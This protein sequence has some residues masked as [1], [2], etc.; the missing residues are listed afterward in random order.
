MGTASEDKQ[1]PEFKGVVLKKTGSK[2]GSRTGSP[3][4][5][6]C[7]SRGEMSASAASLLKKVEMSSSLSS[8]RRGSATSETAAEFANVSLKKT[9]RVQGDQSKFEVEQVSLRPIPVGE[10]EETTV[11]SSSMGMRREERASSVTR[12]RVL[13]ET[14]FEANDEEYHDIKSSLDRLKKKDASPAQALSVEDDAAEGKKKAS[15]KPALAEDDAAAK[16][17]AFRRP[18]RLTRE[19]EEAEKVQLKPIDRQKLSKDKTSAIDDN[20]DDEVAQSLALRRS[21]RMAQEKEQVEKVQLKQVNQEKSSKD[22]SITKDKAAILSLAEEKQEKLTQQQDAEMIQPE[23]VKTKKSSKDAS[24]AK[25]DAA[26]KPVAYRRPKKLP[27]EEEDEAEKVHLKPISREKKTFTSSIECLKKMT[28]EEERQEMKMKMERPV[29]LRKMSYTSSLDNIAI[30]REEREKVH[31]SCF[32]KEMGSNVDLVQV[33][34]EQEEGKHEVKLEFKIEEN[35]VQ[36]SEK[37]IEQKDND[38]QLE[39]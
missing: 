32:S 7:G 33:C 38:G 29:L 5:L 35:D 36:K 22:E 4:R 28:E 30:G 10:G 25:D 13:R 23:S 9:K 19:E 20:E 21:K 6:D 16:P 1:Q 15:Q 3:S 11:S 18:K 17:L 31:L 24:P 27:K 8:S 12:Q 39:E 2:P 14:K 34:Q 26:A 37:P